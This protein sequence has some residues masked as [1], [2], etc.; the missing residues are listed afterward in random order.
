MSAYVQQLIEQD[1]RRDMD[2][3]YTERAYLLALLST[4][5]PS[6]LQKNPDDDPGYEWILFI[7]L[8]T[9]QATWHIKDT[10]AFLFTH[11]RRWASQAVVWDGHT[12]VE[13]LE[14][15]RRALP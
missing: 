2:A 7:E 9:G 11:L 12:T 10:D 5:Y 3:L 13:K 8:P 6:F 14:R 1:H 15:I 4:H